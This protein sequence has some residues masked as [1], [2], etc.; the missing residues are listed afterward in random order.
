[1]LK[2][3]L[4]VVYLFVF[5]LKFR[6]SVCVASVVVVVSSATQ[7]TSSL[8]FLLSPPYQPTI[9]TDKQETGRGIGNF[10]A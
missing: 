3:R 7:L 6:A 5:S 2:S 8:L 10:D 1:M 4:W 9:V